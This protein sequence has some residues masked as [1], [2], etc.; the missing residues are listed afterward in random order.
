MKQKQPID[1]SKIWNWIKKKKKKNLEKRT[2]QF[3]DVSDDGI[4]SKSREM[5]TI[6]EPFYWKVRE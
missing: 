3:N 1:L 5:I 4:R 2:H 6:T